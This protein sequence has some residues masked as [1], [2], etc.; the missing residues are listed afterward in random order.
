MA[1]LHFTNKA[2]EDLSD[3]WNYTVQAWSEHQAAAY[4]EALIQSCHDL[5]SQPSLG[6]SYDLLKINILGFKTGK[7]IIFFRRLGTNEIEIV[8]ILHGRMDIKNHL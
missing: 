8:R 2:V 3:I 6:K 4:Y 1:E 5:A 7:H